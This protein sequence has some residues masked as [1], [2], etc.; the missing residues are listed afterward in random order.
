MRLDTRLN[1][2]GKGSTQRI[3][4]SKVLKMLEDFQGTMSDNS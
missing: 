1:G 4:L 2:D 3:S